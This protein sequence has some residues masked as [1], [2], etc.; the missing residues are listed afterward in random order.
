MKKFVSLL[1]AL[2][3]LTSAN[4]TLLQSA[5]EGNPDLYGIA[6]SLGANSDYMKIADYSTNPNE[7]L[8]KAESYAD[9]YAN[10]DKAEYY[11]DKLHRVA[12]T[13]ELNYAKAVHQG[14]SAGI[15]LLE[16]LSHNGVITPDDIQPE[17][18]DN[19]EHLS[20]ITFSA[21]TDKHITDY[22]AML[23][24]DELNMY[25]NYLT[26]TQSQ[27]KQAD[28]L[29]SLAEKN[30]AEK[31]YFFISAYDGEVYHGM[32]GI[33]VAEGSWTLY[34]KT[35]DKCVLTLSCEVKGGLTGEYGGFSERGCIYINSETKEYYIPVFEKGSEEGL[36]IAAIDDNSLLNFKGTINPSEKIDIDITDLTE[37]YVF[38]KGNVGH[39]L[40]VTAADGT[41]YDGKAY[42]AN[43]CE[44]VATA[45]Y[46]LYGDKFE[47]ETDSGYPDKNTRTSHDLYIIDNNRCV[48]LVS[49]KHQQF[50]VDTNSYTVVNT[51]DFEEEYFLNI[52][53]DKAYCGYNL[54]QIYAN[55][56]TDFTVE[57]TAEGV[58]LSGT[59]GVEASIEL[60]NDISETP[61]EKLDINVDD[62]ILVYLDENNNISFRFDKDNDGEFEQ[63][64][65]VGDANY[66]GK[67]D[68]ID[69]SL[70]LSA[71]AAASTGK[72]VYINE[73]LADCNNDKIIDASDASE[74]LEC[75]AKIQTRIK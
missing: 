45:L 24:H 4:M 1:S 3:M 68:S 44:T 58:I 40:N 27:E 50:I 51:N 52:C 56:D 5:A 72:T 25:L 59:D 20:D 23:A 39:E 26:F 35:Y 2:T 53:F 62:S 60:G 32:A 49:G 14:R 34:G 67:I 10:C 33:G 65:E 30:M 46:Y 12:N 57:T 6:S 21:S 47:I 43:K 61:S 48:E 16:V 17:N 75:Y 9:F 15:A 41:Q 36:L 38:H 7:D 8:T 11:W 31:K 18:A 66:D 69:A 70:V 19:I 28:S 63:N 74:I 71:Y 22:Q 54:W 64:A 55:T 13:K 29:I 42:A 73:K 37:V